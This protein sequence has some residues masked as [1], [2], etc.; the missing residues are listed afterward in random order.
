[1]KGRFGPK[2]GKK[3]QAINRVLY[4]AGGNPIQWRLQTHV[5]DQVVQEDDN[6][7]EDTSS[8]HSNEAD[9]DPKVERLEWKMW[10]MCPKE[11]WIRE[12]EAHWPWGLESP[13]HSER[14]LYFFYLLVGGAS[15]ISEEQKPS[16]KL[17]KLLPV[18]V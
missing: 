11:I 14:G 17:V 1:M 13:G 9:I 15:Y 16:G 2:K 4:M 12:S 3:G 8:L 18:M 5:G 10:D 7:S 6:G